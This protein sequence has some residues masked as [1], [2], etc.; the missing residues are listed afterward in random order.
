MGNMKKYK[1]LCSLL[2]FVLAFSF[3]PEAAISSP[4]S[5]AE[6]LASA[7]MLASLEQQ[8]GGGLQVR[9][10]Q[11]TGKVNFLMVDPGHPAIQSGPS[12]AGLEP[13]GAAR[14]FLAA[15]GV[16]FGINDPY[17]ELSIYNQQPGE[18]GGTVIR[19]QQSA[20]QAGSP[21]VPVLGGEL[22]VQ[23]DASR[24]VLSVN[25]EI[26]PDPQ[27]DPIPLVPAE[28]GRQLALETVANNYE[29]S[30][31]ALKASDPQLAIYNPVILGG[32]GPQ[33]STLVWQVQV[34]SVV[35]AP[36]SE[37]VFV[38]A[39]LG[40]V[41][42][43][44]SQIEPALYRK[45]YNNQNNPNLPT[46]GPNLVRS[47]GQGPTG[48][49]DVDFAYEY[50]G[51]TYN[52]YYS[53][54]GRDSLDG[55]GMQLVS[56]VNYCSPYDTCPYPNAFWDGTQM[57][58][59]YGY[60]SGR[61]VVGHEMTHGFT[62]NTSHLYYHYQSGAINESMSDIFGEFIDRQY[63]GGNDWLLGE[64][65]PGGAVRSLSHPEMFPYYQPD[66]MSSYLYAC[67]ADTI[68][69]RTDDNGGVHTN[70]GI[71][72]KAAYLMAAG[73][74]FNGRTITGIGQAKAAQI[75][76]YAQS[77]LLTSATDYPDLYNDLQ[78]ACSSL[79]PTGKT[80]SADCQQ[81]TL[82]LDAVE[83][84]LQPPSCA[85]PEAPVCPVNTNVQAIMS[86]DLENPGR[87]LWSKGA[88]AGQNNWFYPQNVND[89]SYDATNATSG[90][91][92]FWGYDVNIKADYFIG[93][94]SNV[95]L[96]AGGSYFLRFNHSFSFE[97]PN[98][99][100]GVVE[101][102]TNNGATWADIATLTTDNGYNGTINGGDNPLNGRAAFIYK[103]NCYMSSR[104]N[105]SS[106]GGNNVRFRF[107]IGTNSTGNA[108]GW[109][110]DDISIYSCVLPEKM[111]TSLFIKAYP[112][113]LT[114][115]SFE[116]GVT[117]WQEAS[118]HHV[119]VITHTL[120]TSV[121]AHS[122]SYVAWLGGVYTDT[123]S[124]QQSI[125]IYPGSANLIYWQWISSADP[126]CGNDVASV[127]V[128]NTVVETY[129]L[130]T[131][132]DTFGWV[133]HTVNLNNYKWRTVPVK[134][135]VVTDGKDNS[136]L[137][138]DDISFGYSAP[139]E[140]FTPD[141]QLVVDSASNPRP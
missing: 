47:E 116:S 52:Y 45:I 121:T 120:P 113:T 125:H 11:G 54:F 28:T 15:Y 90:K 96:P 138:I 102:S 77:Y 97:A 36:I 112:T 104:V 66:K 99:D 18:M 140:Q 67:K 13:D 22:V 100:G 49:S 20:S 69:S 2:T 94:N 83:M 86:D 103:S 141:P 70:S 133:K 62:Q 98:R 1:L 39:H 9:Y 118:T 17:R 60:T 53:N 5:S 58:Y 8:T 64:K 50:A 61:D 41:T 126:T 23:L 35:N 71:G 124:I 132:K 26:L 114:N 85:A 37:L 79:I 115:G 91:T 30:V 32:D 43:S 57:V 63:G 4:L 40:L 80:S 119:D 135:Q 122:G 24:S 16:L 51:D 131:S 137:F 55:A 139:V 101:Y 59:G 127:I 31:D 111:I 3:L 123:N 95:F 72:N 92:N 93:M 44:F 108:W 33:V 117:G 105:I 38:D 75:Y 74:T 106:L 34:D 81:V 25:G 87:G 136:N 129:P 130:C 56:T 68:N 48:I 27:F 46:P 88:I 65:L 82:A 19:Y 73:D 12:A 78:L 89:Y 134:I 84:S 29:S 14:Q 107:R 76:Y 110:I 21:P 109:F 6:I 128:D 42:D 7:E 10:H